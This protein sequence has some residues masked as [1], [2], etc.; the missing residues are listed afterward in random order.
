VKSGFVPDFFFTIIT[1]DSM[2]L[3]KLMNA[4][5]L[6]VISIDVQHC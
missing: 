1:K 3:E 6:T 4:F 5:D 2:L